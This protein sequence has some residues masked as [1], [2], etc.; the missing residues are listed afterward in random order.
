MRP[1]NAIR[2]IRT[3][4]RPERSRAAKQAT[5]ER[6]RARAFKLATIEVAR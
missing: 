2:R 6:K 1:Q 5:R 3:S 4:D